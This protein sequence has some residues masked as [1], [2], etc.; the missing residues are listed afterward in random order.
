MILEEGRL[1][2]GSCERRTGRRF[3]VLNLLGVVVAAALVAAIFAVKY[4]L[5][6]RRRAGL[7]RLAEEWGWRFH[8]SGERIVPLP[9]YFLL[10]KRG[11]FQIEDAVG[12]TLAG[13]RDGRAF[14]VFQHRR[15]RM[16]N[17]NE[18]Q[19]HGYPH[20]V[21]LVHCDKLRLPQFTVRRARF[22]NKIAASVA[23]GEVLF[24]DDP[25][26]WSRFRVEGEDAEAIRR[27]LGPEVRDYLVWKGNLVVQGFANELLFYRPTRMLRPSS[28]NA[29]RARRLSEELDRLLDLLLQSAQE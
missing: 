19:R 17:T 27:R 10:S 18:R 2:L 14:F 7:E 5:S 15:Y 4:G 21:A 9:N 12:W 1:T 8:E 22:W 11:A 24:E 23:G 6:K 28:F 3:L 26:F 25:Q 16:R 29:K 13:E 20:N